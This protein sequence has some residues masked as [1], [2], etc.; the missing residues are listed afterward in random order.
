M[1]RKEYIEALRRRGVYWKGGEPLRSL[2][3]KWLPYVTDPNW[4]SIERWIDFVNRLPNPEI[5]SKLSVREAL[6]RL[7]RVNFGIRGYRIN[8][9]PEVLLPLVRAVHRTLQAVATEARPAGIDHLEPDPF[10]LFT[11]ALGLADQTRVRQC[12]VCGRLLF[13]KRR[14]KTACAGACSDT[15]RQR[16]FR[17]NKHYY[18]NRKRNRRAKAA[19]EARRKESIRRALQGGRR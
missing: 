7:G 2:Q 9:D 10:T 15:A 4:L 8:D 1:T 11:T 3:P 12:S 5:L 18:P 13:A 19:Q 16:R 17:E 6:E 14:D